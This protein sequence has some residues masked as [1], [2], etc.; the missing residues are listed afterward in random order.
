[1]ALLK[2]SIDAGILFDSCSQA[3]NVGVSQKQIAIESPVVLGIIC[4][5]AGTVAVTAAAPLDED[6]PFLQVWSAC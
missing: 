2:D 4:C 1:M 6:V 3:C 5:T